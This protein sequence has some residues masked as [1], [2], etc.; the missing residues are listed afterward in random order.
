M[1]QVV[2]GVSVVCLHFVRCFSVDVGCFRVAAWLLST[3]CARAVSLV[4]FLFVAACAEAEIAGLKEALQI[5]ENESAPAFLQIR[6][7]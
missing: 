1:W 4:L 2:V 3:W 7:A 6:R 5:L